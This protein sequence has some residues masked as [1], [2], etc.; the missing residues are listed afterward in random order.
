MSFAKCKEVQTTYFNS[1][2]TYLQSLKYFDSPPKILYERPVIILRY[3]KNIIC[4][5]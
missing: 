1:C 5:S 2:L 4:P 3:Y